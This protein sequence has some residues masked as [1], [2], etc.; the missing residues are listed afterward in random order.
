MA[1]LESASAG[2]VPGYDRSVAPSI[3]HLGVGAFAR[4]HLGV[5]ADDLLHAGWPAMVRGVSLRSP[6]AEEQL[7]PQDGLYSVLER[8]PGAETPMRVVGSLASV[9]TGP[10][11]AI[12]AIASPDTSL[13]TLTVTE[14]GYEPDA[15]AAAVI[16]AGLARRPEGAPAPVIASL[17][18]VAGNGALLRA[19]VLAVAERLDPALGRRIASAVPFPSSVVDRMVPATTPADLDRVA[20]RLG[21]RDLAAVVAEHHRSW[22]I[23]ATDRLP[24]LADAGV[25]V[26][27]DVAPYERRKLWLL[28]G[29]HSAFA[30]GGLVAGCTTIAEAV[31]H[32][33]VWAFVR[34]LVDEVLEV[35]DLPA[36][37]QPRRFAEEALRR[38][39]NPD[40][41]H[42][43]AQ[44]ATDGSQKLRQRLLPVV[45]R[46]RELGLGTDRFALVTAIWVGAVGGV[47][48][49]GVLLPRLADPAA[50]AD[51]D[52]LVTALG[53][54]RAFSAQVVDALGR[55]TREGPA[56]L[57]V[58]A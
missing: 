38:F 15:P 6:T 19:R 39:A 14:K 29:P 22:V 28:N 9:A 23:G 44:V 11:A 54:D 26:V 12:E 35:A 58:A 49:R 33:G 40:L 7:G 45:A 5:F 30:Y 41:G 57:E 42:T 27:P 50:G 8:E 51:V 56:V 3:V 17:D 53:A 4:A 47:S 25:E 43:C 37:T 36:S 32:V 20:E 2:R 21:V 31:S 52:A 1:T 16:A 10:E 48:M 24:P 18:N 55:L 13:V 46:R 34:L